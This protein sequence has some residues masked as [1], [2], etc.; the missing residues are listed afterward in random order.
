MARHCEEQRDKA[1]QSC[2][3][4]LYGLPRAFQALAMTVALLLVLPVAIAHAAC[5]NPAGEAGK[6]INNLDEAMLQYCDGTNWI[7]MGPKQVADL[8]VAAMPTS[9][10]VGWWKLDEGTGSTTAADSSGNANNGTLTNMDSATDWVTGRLSDALDFDGVNDYVSIPNNNASLRF[11]GNGTISTWVKMDS[12]SSGYIFEK[13]SDAGT[14]EWG[15]FLAM[16]ADG[17]PWVAVV[18]TD[19]VAHQHSL[20]STTAIQTGQWVHI[21]GVWNS[22][23]LEIYINGV[24]ADIQNIGTGTLRTG[25]TN[26]SIIGAAKD[27]PTIMDPFNGQID[28]VRLYNR[29]L[30]SEEIATLAGASLQT[31]LVG[32]WK[33]DETSG[34]PAIR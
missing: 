9:G 2:K 34:L 25:T 20:Y 13:Q 14:N 16:T 7:A 18:H 32:W 15:M 10:L 30:T 5:S 28:D 19:G 27:V 1:I 33:L 22:P 6:I 31:G 11:T 26:P 3:H 23:N 12:L 24:L 8:N 4:K 17:R 29:A 21:A